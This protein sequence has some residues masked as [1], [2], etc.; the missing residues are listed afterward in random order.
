[1]AAQKGL[2]LLLYLK[3]LAFAEK[4][5]NTNEFWERNSSYN[6]GAKMCFI[7]SQIFIVK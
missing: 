2:A 4:F 1:M 3:T 6:I 5:E 7:K